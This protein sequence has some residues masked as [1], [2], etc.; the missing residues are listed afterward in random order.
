MAFL[1]LFGGLIFLVRLATA[2]N[3]GLAVTPQMG[4][5]DWN[6]FGCSLSQSLILSTASVIKNTGLRDLGYH[7]IILDD[8]WSSGRGSDGALIPDTT[9]FPNGMSYLGAQLHADSFGFG[10]YS[11]AGTKTFL[12]WQREKCAGYPGSLG[13]ETIDA[14]TFASWGVDYLKYDNCNNNGEA[15]SQAASSDRYEAMEQALAASGRQIL[16]A[17]CNWG[18][19]QPWV[20]GPSVGNSWRITGDISD[21]FNTGNSACAV[22]NY[23]GYECSVT[24][25]MSMQATISSYSVKGGW[26]DLDMLEVGNGGMSDS[27]YVAHFSMWSV[28]KSPLIMG[29]DMSKLTASAYSILANP[30]IIA[31][32]QDPLGVAA[33]YR[34][35]RNNVQLWSGPLVSTT[36]SSINDVV[37]VLFNN[38]G[39]S[40]TASAT[41]SDIFG[42]LKV[43]LS[44][45]EIRDLWASRLNDSQAQAILNDGATAH[46]SWFYNATAQ[47]YSTGLSQ[48]NSMLLGGV[49]GTVSGAAGTISQSIPGTGCRVFR[50]RAISGTATTTTTS[51]SSATGSSTQ[52]QQ[53]KWG[54]CGGQG[55][56]GQTQCVP[57][58]TCQ[59]Q[60]RKCLP[61]GPIGHCLTYILTECF[62]ILPEWYSQCL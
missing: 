21:N 49:I 5:D 14:N 50:L 39:S 33:T 13:Y 44:Q 35:T 15:G 25:I 55:W 7:Y 24:Q 38:G 57:P 26:N 41:L 45:F 9:K 54:Q 59:A 22:P 62:V 20:W 60:N 27:E 16:Y 43:P 36:G 34:W 11:S 1:V 40:T 8:C 6:A 12:T 56:T 23:G 29:N 37:V 18:Q 58:S 2:L 28:S 32:N 42:S 61:S 31:V 48:G 51:A 17:I 46:P 52:P 4:W 10:I 3:N 19:D 47:S 53:T 30:A